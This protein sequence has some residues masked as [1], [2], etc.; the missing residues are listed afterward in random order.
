L[1]AVLSTSLAAHTESTPRLT[2]TPA[3]IVANAGA[4]SSAD[5]SFMAKAATAATRQ[6]TVSQAVMDQLSNPQIKSFAQQVIA[7][8]TLASSDLTALA[9][10]KGIEAH[11]MRGT[12]LPDDRSWKV[13]NVDRQ[14]VREMVSGHEEAVTLFEDASASGDQDIAAFAQKTL[15]ELRH[16]LTVAQD[17]Q[18]AID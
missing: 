13:A 16:Q 6:I 17:L 12:P 4:L 5:M 15:P 7:V 2:P 11:S 9:E 14:Y 18:K 8:A 10:Q 3:S 1:L